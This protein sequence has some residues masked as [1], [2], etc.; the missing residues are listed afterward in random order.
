MNTVTRRRFMSLSG[1]G[2]AGAGLLAL[3]PRLFGG[4][5]PAPSPVGQPA[6]AS[7]TEPWPNF[8]EPIVAY[9]HAPASGQLS[10]MVGTRE[11]AVTDPD[12]VGRLIQRVSSGR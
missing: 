1:A 11:V 9:V 8:D 2:A 6:P 4:G 12:L 10:L 3:A 7:V 5:S